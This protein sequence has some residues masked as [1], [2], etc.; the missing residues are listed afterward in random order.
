MMK[1]AVSVVL[2]VCA[3]AA[4]ANDAKSE[5]ADVILGELFGSNVYDRQNGIAAIA[6]GTSSC[7]AGDKVIDWKELPDKKHPIIALNMYRLLDGRMTQIGQSWVKHGQFALQGNECNFGCQAH[8][9]DG[10]GV[11]CSDPYGVGMNRGP[12]LGS[13]LAI[14][15]TTGDFDGPAQKQEIDNF[16]PST[17]IDRGLQ[18]KESDLANS[19]ARYFMEGHYIAADDA[20]ANNAYNNVSH[21]EVAVTQAPGGGFDFRNV[22]STPHPTVRERPAILAWPFAEF[23]ISD[24]QNEGRIIVAHKPV[25]ISRT[26]FRYEYAVYN[27]NSDRG[28]QS[29]S[30]PVGQAQVTNVGF[31]AV[32]SHGGPLENDPWQAVT[33]NGRVTWAAK[34]FQQTP[35]ANA[36]RWGTMYNFWFEAEGS[37]GR[38]DASLGRFKPGAAAAAAT[39]NV[40]APRN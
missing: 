27:M 25:R 23:S 36:I 32:F 33:G 20:A 11:G 1:P 19:G 29:F 34:T 6:V 31:Q 13:R 9:S 14:N 16:N 10:L 38:A 5:G 18:V 2:V 8:G 30:V 7:N 35:N 26:K 39:V 17:T 3:L 4:V 40:Q 28:V 15:P 22:V 37:P 24:V 12:R 21:I